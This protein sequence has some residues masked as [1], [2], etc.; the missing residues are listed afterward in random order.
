M[1]FGRC[2]TI[3]DS[4]FSLT[5]TS[6]LI[7]FNQQGQ[8]QN[9]V[10]EIVQN[11]QNITALGESFFSLFSGLVSNTQ[12]D[13]QA[14]IETLNSTIDG[15]TVMPQSLLSNLGL[16]F[17]N[18]AGTING[19]ELFNSVAAINTIQTSLLTALQSHLFTAVS[20][21]NEQDAVIQENSETGNDGQQT[22]IMNELVEFSFGSNGL[23]INDG[24][25]TF[26]I[27][28]HVPIVSTVYQESSGQSI[29]AISK[30]SGGYIYGGPIGLAFSA[31]DIAVEHMSGKS[32]SD[33]LVNFNYSDL[34]SSDNTQQSIESEISNLTNTFSLVKQR[35][36]AELDAPYTTK[37]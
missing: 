23:D 26:N 13:S 10:Q 29:S 34:F 11:V 5:D 14:S 32:I 24:F 31:L 1:L 25:D 12:S 36:Q 7:P 17:L 8:T 30:L 2:M 18:G 37:Q 16:N 19:A 3:P 22:N 35:R 33:Q 21:Q 20:A 15:S 28:Q 6:S 27:L 9:G 4:N